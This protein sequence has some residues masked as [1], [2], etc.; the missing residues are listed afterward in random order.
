VSDVE[1]HHLDF[2]MPYALTNRAIVSMLR[3]EYTDA[4]VLIDEAE[5]RATAAGDLTASF[6]TWAVRTR[7]FN[8]QGA[9]DVATARPMPRVSDVTRSLEAELAACYALAYAG[10]GD[11]RRAV[12][13]ATRALSG[14]IAAEVAIT[15]P[16]AIAVAAAKDRDHAKAKLNAKKALD[17]T[18]RSGMIESFVCA[19]R[20]CP[21][22]IVSLL[23]D[24]TTHEGLE[25][26]LGMAGDASIAPSGGTHSVM[27]LSKREKEVLGL[28]G[29]GMSNVEIGRQLFISP[30]TVKVHVRHIFEKLG[31]KSRAEAAL[32]AAQISRE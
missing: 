20:G 22:L 30:V 18:T 2:V 24:V 21:E 29:Q 14:S 16:C 23:A 12:A 15:A 28:V 19:Y 4:E 7:L 6:I 3:R 13:H 8:A 9:F 32:R 11:S 1:K 27:K 5:Q 26:T 25:R 10:A 31:V 17:A